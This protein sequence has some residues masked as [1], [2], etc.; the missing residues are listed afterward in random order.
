MAGWKLET[1]NWK[2][3]HASSPS[4]EYAAPSFLLCLLCYSVGRIPNCAAVQALIIPRRFQHRHQLPSRLHFP[5]GACMVEDH[6]LRIRLF[7]ASPVR[8]PPRIPS[9]SHL[10][11]PFTRLH[12]PRLCFPTM[13]EKGSPC[14]PVPYANLLVLLSTL[15]HRHRK[16]LR[17]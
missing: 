10:D 17:Y 7:C 6:F 1:G 8:A 3:G 13:S 2:D 9:R 5:H 14:Q 12:W 11:R 4:F 16:G 15:H